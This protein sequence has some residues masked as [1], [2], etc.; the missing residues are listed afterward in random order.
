[1]SHPFFYLAILFV[2]A[3]ISFDAI[4]YKGKVTPLGIY[5]FCYLYFCFGPYLAHVLGFSIYSGIQKEYLEQAALVFAFGL[6][7]LAILPLNSLAK[8]ELPYSLKVKEPILVKQICLLS[9]SLPVL[10][11]FALAFARI[12][13]SGLDKVQRI[14]MLGL[15]HYI[16]LTLWPLLLFA[17]LTVTPRNTLTA[18]E[19]VLFTAI[20]LLYFTYCF[21]M[22]ERDFALLALPLFFWMYKERRIAPLKLAAGLILAVVGFTAMSLGRGDAFEGNGLSAFLNQGSNLMVTS[23]ILSWLDSGQSY[24]F[25]QSYFSGIVNMMTLGA[26]K[27]TLPMSIW[28][29]RN[30]SS[31]ANDGAYGFSIEGEA[32]INFGLAGVPFLFAFIG[33]FLAWCYRGYLANR[34]LGVLLT[35]FNLFYFIYAIRGESLILFK[36]LIYCLIL[37]VGLLFI[38]QRGRLYFQ[39]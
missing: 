18:R 20:I 21:Y 7:A 10:A 16:L 4:H 22:G 30:Y 19:G 25:G 38:S 1:M 13:F 28:F 3:R 37:F 36:A 2:I 5:S 23:N 33:F 11:L 6:G 26:V 29:S 31:A 15:P 35:Y 8:L 17:L 27:L 32:L 12:G 39:V 14:Q 24:L 34:P 9:L